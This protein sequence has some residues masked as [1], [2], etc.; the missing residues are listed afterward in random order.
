MSLLDLLRWVVLRKDLQGAVPK[1]HRFNRC[2][3]CMINL[4][5]R[6]WLAMVVC[7]NL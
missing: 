5:R 6:V 7:L 1:G 2:G 3:V 4:R